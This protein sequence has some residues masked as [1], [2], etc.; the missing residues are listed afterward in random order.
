MS[1]NSVKF[2]VYRLRFILVNFSG[3]VQLLISC[4]RHCRKYMLLIM[5]YLDVLDRLV[6]MLRPSDIDPFVA[7]RVIST[8][9]HLVYSDF[10]SDIGVTKILKY[11]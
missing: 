1:M 7:S 9:N 3:V 11:I 10:K 5:E 8:A 2:F 6:T 4:Y